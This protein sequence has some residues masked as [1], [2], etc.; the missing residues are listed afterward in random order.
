MKCPQCDSMN[1]YVK[2]S[3]PKEDETMVNRRHECRDCGHRFTTYQ[4]YKETYDEMHDDFI[5]DTGKVRK[6]LNAVF[7]V[8]Q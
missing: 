7:E 3:R 4:I 6:L 1:T 8:M 2:D 5:K